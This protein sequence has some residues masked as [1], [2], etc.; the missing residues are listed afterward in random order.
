M[1]L[2]WL[3]VTLITGGYMAVPNIDWNQLEQIAETDSELRSALDIVTAR[4]PERPA[5]TTFGQADDEA[6]ALLLAHE[7]DKFNTA[8]QRHPVYED[9]ELNPTIGYGHLLSD[10]EIKSETITIDGETYN[11]ND[12]LDEATAY[13]L[14]EEDFQIHKDILFA[15][16][17]LNEAVLFA[18]SP[19]SDVDYN[20]A[21]AWSVGDNTNLGTPIEYM[22]GS[23]KRIE[24]ASNGDTKIFGFNNRE[25]VLAAGQARYEEMPTNVQAAVLSVTYNYGSTGPETI[26]K[27]NK[28]IDTENFA[29]LAEHYDTKLA[30]EA[31][32]NRRRD[33][34][35]LIRTGQSVQVRQSAEMQGSTLNRI[36]VPNVFAGQ[37]MT[38][39]AIGGSGMGTRSPSGFNVGRQM[40]AGDRDDLARF[41]RFQTAGQTGGFPQVTGQVD[42]FAKEESRKFLEEQYGAYGFFLY[43]NNKDLQVGVDKFGVFVPVDDPS[44]LPE[45]GGTTM[46]ILDAIEKE[47][48]A[49]TGDTEVGL[50]RIQEILG[51]TK[52]GMENNKHQRQFDVEFADLNEVEQQ[53]YLD[54]EMENIKKV[55]Q[56]MGLTSIDPSTGA[57]GYEFSDEEV[58]QLAYQIKRL[59][60]SDD[61]FFIQ[62]MVSAQVEQKSVVNEY[63]MYQSLINQN[64]AAASNYYVDVKD[65]QVQK[66]TEEIFTGKRAAG[67]WENYL[68]QQAFAKYP[69]LKEILS[70]L[71]MTPKEYFASTEASIEQL[72]G[73]QI[74]L[75]DEKY[76]PI[77]NYIDEKT[78]QV[79]ALTGWEASEYI[80]GTDEYLTSTSGQNKILQMVEGIA[81]AF[82]KAAY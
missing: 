49:L 53:E 43:E 80:R 42:P 38:G 14:F 40:M 71:G 51:F 66:F 7:G 35:N 4:M 17:A 36:G 56:F 55:L 11:L 19:D 15:E 32:P 45:N 33:E 28:A 18:D 77:L 65:E 68:Q 62:S 37:D 24:V 34:A 13:K 44:A 21:S 70:E 29:A 52:W 59:N 79:R 30:S 50:T 5:R 60:K 57:L 48:A 6:K 27:V 2:N 82:G 10:D 25:E 64:K 61:E 26:R 3:V 22:G 58:F 73:K 67:E 78:G 75:G 47:D 1:I 23:E 63:N 81:S 54:S 20:W 76:S 9:S 72:L 8:T 74:N 46:N 16:L 31:N 12:G 39:F 41:N 69:H